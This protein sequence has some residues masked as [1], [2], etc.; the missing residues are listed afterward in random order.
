MSW[1]VL[2]AW[3]L[4]RPQAYFSSLPGMQQMTARRMPYSSAARTLSPIKSAM[5][6]KA[7]SGWEPKI[8]RP[9]PSLVQRRA[10]FSERPP[11]QKN[12]VS[13]PEKASERTQ[14]R[15]EAM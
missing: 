13:P 11:V 12:M 7:S 3:V 15:M 6:V 5:L 1:A 8:F 9:A 10:A 4:K 2:W 14:R